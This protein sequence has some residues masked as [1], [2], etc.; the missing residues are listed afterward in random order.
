MSA[1]LQRKINS[2]CEQLENSR[3]QIS[4]FN[5]SAFLQSILLVGSAWNLDIAQA[6]GYPK[7]DSNT[8]KPRVEILCKLPSESKIYDSITHRWIKKKSPDSDNHLALDGSP[9]YSF[10]KRVDYFNSESVK[11]FHLQQFNILIE[12]RLTY[13][14]SLKELPEDWISGHSIAPNEKVITKGRDFLKEF[15]KRM[16]YLYLGCRIPKILMGPIPDGGISFTFI[17]DEDNKLF[18]RILNEKIIE[19]DIEHK[20]EYT[21]KEFNNFDIN[22]T[23]ILVDELVKLN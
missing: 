17:V 21:L 12:N 19:V 18:F 10:N 23:D 8:N 22:I 7:L 14:D 9:T 15:K 2:S 16:P 1:S 11:Y 5:P 6:I 3:K 13:V 4:N 20:G